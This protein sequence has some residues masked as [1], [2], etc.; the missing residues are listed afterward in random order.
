MKTVFLSGAV[1]IGVLARPGFGGDAPAGHEWL[2]QLVGEWDIRV[3]TFME[4][5]P[6]TGTDSVRAI[7]DHWVVADTKSTMMGVPFRGNL[8]LGYDDH[9]ERFH[10]TW[11]DSMSGYL[12]VYDGSL[13]DARD[14]LTLRTEGPGME[15]PD[16]IVKWR[17]VVRITGEG[18]RTFTSSMQAEDGTWSE[19]L[20]IEYDRR[21]VSVADGGGSDAEEAIAV[22]YLEVVTS[23]VDAT[24]TALGRVHQVSFSEPEAGVG[25]ARTAALKGGGRIGV[26]AP[27]A[28]H[29][30]PVVRTY[31][32]V[33]DIEASIREAEAA[34]AEFAMLATEIPGRGKFAIYFLGGI[35]HGF[36]ER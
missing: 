35:Q 17:E 19:I 6:S 12:W 2:A 3:T 25:G 27:M 15:G 11:I 24:C 20:K 7:G 1:L 4:A 16:T 29:E 8:S 30:E 14:T 34:G 13:N 9:K 10:A 22:Q 26:R 21:S 33:E 32:L 31:V 18:S 5:E 36:W 28:A 23:D